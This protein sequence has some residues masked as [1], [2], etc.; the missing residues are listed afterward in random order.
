MREDNQPVLSFANV[1]GRKVEGTFDGGTVTS[2]AGA[3]VLRE[4]DRRDG[5]RAAALAEALPYGRSQAVGRRGVW[6]RS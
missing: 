6:P 2:D 3:L 4:I 1:A 5:P